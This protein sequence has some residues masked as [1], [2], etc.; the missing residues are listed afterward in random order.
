[1]NIQ[2]HLPSPLVCCPLQLGGRV[3]PRGCRLCLCA[4][5]CRQHLALANSAV[6]LH[7]IV[8]HKP[9]RRQLHVALLIPLNPSVSLSWSF[10]LLL[11]QWLLQCWWGAKAAQ[12]SR[13][14]DPASLAVLRVR[15]PPGLGSHLAED[16][17]AQNSITQTSPS[18]VVAQQDLL[19]AMEALVT[20]EPQNL[21]ATMAR[22]RELELWLSV[23]NCGVRSCRHQDVCEPE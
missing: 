19:P 8:W 7:A 4:L 18:N 23:P 6:A 16:F 2:H 1:M 15:V 10:P 5:S 12:Q 22:K 11:Q 20:N 21:E 13:H 3:S 9:R 14:Q 17:I